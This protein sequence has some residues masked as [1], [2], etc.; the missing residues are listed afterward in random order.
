MEQ[1]QVL[2]AWCMSGRPQLLAESWRKFVRK[3]ILAAAKNV[4][5]EESERREMETLLSV[6]DYNENSCDR[7]KHLTALEAF[8]CW[9]PEAASRG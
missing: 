8:L 9:I 3:W 5:D 2:P 7:E 1:V 6:Q 4:S